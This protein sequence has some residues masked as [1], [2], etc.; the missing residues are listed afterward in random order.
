VT[1]DKVMIVLGVVMAL[2]ALVQLVVNQRSKAESSGGISNTGSCGAMLLGLSMVGRGLHIG[3]PVLWLGVAV[4]TA[5]LVSYSL[6]V[7]LRQAR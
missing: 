5:L 4:L 6:F 1:D 2:I 3:P 7:T